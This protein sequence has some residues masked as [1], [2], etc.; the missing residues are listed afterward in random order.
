MIDEVEKHIR[1]TCDC[2]RLIKLKRHFIKTIIRPGMLY[3]TECWV[4]LFIK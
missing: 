2:R 4:V 1:S 3:G